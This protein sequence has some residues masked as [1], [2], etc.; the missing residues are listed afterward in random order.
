MRTRRRLLGLIL[1][2]TTGAAASLYAQPS[3]RACDEAPRSRLMVR[4]RARVVVEGTRSV[5]N[6]REA[7]DL[8]SDNIDDIPRGA[9]VFVLE[10]PECADDYAWFLVRYRGREGWIAEG[11]DENYFVETYPP[12]W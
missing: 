7:A 4:E 12:G 1:I 10:G 5:L 2:L 9:L 3:D 6:R 11:D 8:G